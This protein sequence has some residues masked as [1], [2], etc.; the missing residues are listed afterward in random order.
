[1]HEKVTNTMGHGQRVLGGFAAA[2]I[3][4]ATLVAG[5]VGATSASAATTTRSTTTTLGGSRVLD[6]V[7]LADTSLLGVA[8]QAG[9]LDGTLD[10]QQMT[11]VSTQYDDDAVRQGRAVD[12]VDAATRPFPGTMVA[13]WSLADLQVAFP[14]F[15]GFDVGTIGLSS[16]GP[17]NLRYGG[18]AYVCHLQSDSSTILDSSPTPGPYVKAALAVD[19]TITPR[20]LS[21]VR[22]ASVA[23]TPLGTTNLSLGESPV[24]DP[25]DV[26]CDVGVGDHLTYAL[27]A[28]ST[29]PGVDVQASLQLQVGTSVVNPAYP[30]SDANPVVYLPPLASPSFAFA[31][32]ATTIAMS[33]RG[34]SFDLGGVLPDDQPVTAD[35][36]GPYSGTEGSAI[37][38][39]GSTTATC[40]APTLHW[41]FSDGGSADGAQPSH[42]FAD[43]GTYTG[44][45]TATK[46]TQTAT[47]TLWVTVAN[48]APTADAGPDTSSG[49][50]TAVAFSGTATD[51]G[52]VDQ[53]GL[54]YSWD[55]GDGSPAA[56]GADLTHTFTAAGA[57][58]ATLTVCDKDGGCATDVRQVTVGAKQPSALLYFGDLIGRTGRTADFRAVLVDRKARPL[59]GRV[60]TFTVAGQSVTA[61]TDS[62]GIASTTATITAR[63]GLH[64]VTA[65]WR[66]GD[67]QYTGASM[68]LPFIVL[69]R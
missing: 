50:G 68:T 26:G 19:L 38:L 62:R 9:G 14:G 6:G 63:R 3:G 60:V 12:P 7:A 28:M 23:G 42:V 10:W 65:S 4:V 49:V 29:T 21:S 24:A 66:L 13:N 5:V 46:G 11:T 61:T 41:Q 2:C 34:A 53:A 47:S 59:V 54:R 18:D 44:T 51:P 17:C 57:Y 37:A 39:Q 56:T 40:G 55:F 67:A 58:D 69:T 31:P 1:L 32:V 25:L 45:L 15:S 16:S 30:A 35:A 43:D 48:V 27:G 22:T 20:A 64:T 36:G 33:G 52:P 8:V